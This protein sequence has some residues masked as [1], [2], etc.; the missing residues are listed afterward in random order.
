MGKAGEGD[1]EVA[2]FGG[3]VSE[4]VE[5]E[6]GSPRGSA[7]GLKFDIDDCTGVAAFVPE[8]Q[9]LVAAQVERAS[10]ALN[11]A[12]RLH[13]RRSK[14]PSEPLQ[15]FPEPQPGPWEGGVRTA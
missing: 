7:I 9:G 10:Q 2:P 4:G 6:I 8:A 14:Q 3:I 11:L 5:E 1:G 15:L 12:G 13:V